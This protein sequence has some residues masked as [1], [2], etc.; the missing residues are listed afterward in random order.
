MV[1]IMD[2]TSGIRG[3]RNKLKKIK[4]IAQSL[5]DAKNELK[6]EVDKAANELEETKKDIQHL[7]DVI[8]KGE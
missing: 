6:N 1:I 8:R 4:T 2:A 7:I 5:E 3:I